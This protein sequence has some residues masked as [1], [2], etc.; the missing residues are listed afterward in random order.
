[1]SH[2]RT[3]LI[4]AAVTIV[5]AVALLAFAGM[6]EGWVYYLPVD[7]FASNPDYQTSRVR[8]HGTVAEDGLLIQK[9][10]LTARFELRGETSGVDVNYTGVLPD[11]F[12][13]GRD[14]VVEGKLD[15]SG[16]F[17]ADTLMTKC[18]SK[19]ESEDG[20]AP[21]TDPRGPESTE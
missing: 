16:V 17:Q 1:M 10:L 15:E 20:Q 21:H 19:Y 18:A 7:D 11:M 8:L 6:R 13:A 2:A 9:A 5:A 12:E 4:V 14:V 3:K